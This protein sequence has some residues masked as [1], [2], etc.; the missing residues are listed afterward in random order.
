MITLIYKPFKDDFP[1][2]PA[3]IR[4]LKMELT[5]D[6]D[7]VEA[8]QEFQNFLRAAGYKIPY[9]PLDNHPVFNAWNEVQTS[10]DEDETFPRGRPE[11]VRVQANGPTL[12]YMYPDQD[13]SI[14][15]G[16]RRVITEKYLEPYPESEKDI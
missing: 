6:I 16:Y 2:D 7:W 12:F 1:C 13:S 5:D 14:P 9:S 8:T 15:E 4:E 11:A 3:P 10:A